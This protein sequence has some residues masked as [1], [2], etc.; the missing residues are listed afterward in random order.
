MAS[1]PDLAVMFVISGW[2]HQPSEDAWLE[3]QAWDSGE[4]QAA[5]EEKG[6]AGFKSWLTK[7][8]KGLGRKG[9][10]CWMPTRFALTGSL[11]GCELPQ[12]VALLLAEDGDVA[13]KSLIVPIAERMDQLRAFVS[14]QH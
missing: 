7:M 4:I 10:R 12:L 13:D 14:E 9:A 11:H 2:C 1:R 6:P 5:V 8:G 3:L